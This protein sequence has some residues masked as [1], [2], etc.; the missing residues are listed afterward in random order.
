MISNFKFLTCNV[1]NIYSIH[2]KNRKDKK[3]WSNF[4]CFTMSKIILLKRKKKEKGEDI[5]TPFKDFFLTIKLGDQT[6]MLKKNIGILDD[7]L[8]VVFLSLFTIS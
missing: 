4:C 7:N 3:I 6:S 5:F 8:N 1:L 2:D